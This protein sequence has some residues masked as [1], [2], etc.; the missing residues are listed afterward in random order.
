MPH[1]HMRRN[2]AHLPALRV[3][4]P[5]ATEPTQPPLPRSHPALPSPA[6]CAAVQQSGEPSSNMLA[7][8]FEAL[9][10]GR[11]RGRKGRA[12]A[13]LVVRRA[14]QHAT[15]HQRALSIPLRHN[16]WSA[17]S[18]SCLRRAPFI[19]TAI[20]RRCDA[21][22]CSTSRCRRTRCRCCRQTAPA[23]CRGRGRRTASRRPTPGT[24][25]PARAA[26]ESPP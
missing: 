5:C 6:P 11:E 26:A 13:R 7:E 15:A 20:W 14:V 3:P 4:A 8:M 19:W 18:W 22:T 10:V 17:I 23:G 1:H 24:E 12:G 25:P 9:M 2:L 16:V 21:A